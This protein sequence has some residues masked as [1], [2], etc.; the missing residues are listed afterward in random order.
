VPPAQVAR[1]LTACPGLRVS[2]VHT[3]AGT[4]APAA[5]CHLDD[6]ADLTD[7]LPAGRP[8]PGTTALV[9]DAD[10]RLAPPGALGE[11]HLYDGSGPSGPLP[12]TRRTPDSPHRLYPTGETAR[13]DGT[14]RLRV[15][16][17]AGEATV[18]GAR[19]RLAA[20][21]AALREH[22]EVADAVVVRTAGGELLAGVVAPDDPS[23]PEALRVHTARYVPSRSVPALWALVAALPLLPDGA[24]DATELL[25]VATSADAVGRPARASADRPRAAAP[26]PSPTSGARPADV[27][28]AVRSAWQEALGA[29]AF[30]RDDVFFDVGG[31]SMRML[32]LRASLHRRLPGCGVTVQDLYRHPTVAGLADHLR[33]GETA[34]QEEPE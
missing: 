28:N 1:V 18:R 14:G 15:V 20:V 5:V 26:Q 23:L 2:L 33:G 32:T 10:G 22:P 21:A 12:G 4:A 3:P 16:P 9:L 11:L 31:T 13:W 34:R 27:E 29:G 8:L 19:V 6:P 24:P 30:G 25:R 17:S 7:P